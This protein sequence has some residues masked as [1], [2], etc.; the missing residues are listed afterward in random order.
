[1]KGI[2]VVNAFP[3]EEYPAEMRKKIDFFIVKDWVLLSTVEVK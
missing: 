2:G 3:K 1:M